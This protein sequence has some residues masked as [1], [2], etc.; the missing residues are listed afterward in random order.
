[1]TYK[2]KIVLA[3]F[4][5]DDFSDTKPRP[6]LCL[7]DPIGENFHVVGAFISTQVPPTP[8]LYDIIFDPTQQQW[9]MSGLRMRSILRLHRMTTFDVSF[10]RKTLGVWPTP[11]RP[12]VADRLRLLFDL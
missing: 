5:F 6:V 4:P 3:P 9:Q 1:M 12:P 2:W 7:T 10:A 8:D 11:E